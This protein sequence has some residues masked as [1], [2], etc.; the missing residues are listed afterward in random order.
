MP[1]NVK[2]AADLKSYPGPPFE[3]D[4]CL[5][6]KLNYL[7]VLFLAQQA[8]LRAPQ[9]DPRLLNISEQLLTIVVEAMMLRHRLVNSG[10]G[11]I[12]KVSF[13]LPRRWHMLTVFGNKVC[14]YG[15]PAAGTLSLYILQHS[16]ESHQSPPLVAWS[17]VLN[18]LRIFVAEIQLGGLVQVDEPNYA[19]L[20]R[21]AR[22]IQ[23][24][25]ENME[26]QRERPP[27]QPS[28]DHQSRM[29]FDDWSES[30]GSDPWGFELGFWQNLAGH[31]FLTDTAI[32]QDA[33][34]IL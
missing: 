16:T 7:Q 18:E 22:T 21:A 5:S 12:W 8:L 29:V 33:A 11:F 13:I 24:L 28:V 3:R 30:L 34:G 27:E 20:S 15:L 19:L 26:P 32:A 14:H 25:I 9:T 10:T 17:K 6:A 23:A 4:F 1:M 31:P 2:T